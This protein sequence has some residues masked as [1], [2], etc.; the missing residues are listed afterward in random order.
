VAASTGA[1]LVLMALAPWPIGLAFV[2]SAAAISIGTFA[3]RYHFS[4]DAIAGSVVAIIV[5]LVAGW[6]APY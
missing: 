2:A 5:F 4:S 6:L 3:G 1:A